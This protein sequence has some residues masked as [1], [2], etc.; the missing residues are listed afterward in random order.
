MPEKGQAC[1]VGVVSEKL[2]LFLPIY[3]AWA[4]LGSLEFLFVPL[5]D[6]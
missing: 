2:S 1:L 3:V 5:V 4:N 6:A